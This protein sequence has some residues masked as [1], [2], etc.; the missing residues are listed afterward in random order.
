MNRCP[1]CASDVPEGKRFCGDCGAPVAKAASAPTET[2]VSGGSSDER[3]SQGSSAPSFDSQDR[4]RF[5]P[6]TVLAGRYRIVGLIGS[7]G[8]GE[9]YRADDLRLG[10]PVALKFL[11]AEFEKDP[12]RLSRFMGEVRIARQVTHPNVCR[13]YDVGEADGK[14]F[15]SMEYV[16]GEDLGSLL[17]RIGRLP[18]DK[19]VQLAR[20]VC[21]GLAAAH[22]QGILHRDLK[23]ANVMIDGRGRARLTDF[24]LAGLA[25]A[26]EGAEV[27]AGTPAY[28]APE[29]LSGKGVSMKSDLY[30]LGLVLY[31]LFTGKRAFDAPTAAELM[32]LQQESTPAMP[33]THVSGLDPAV[34]SVILRCLDKEPTQRP[35]SALAVAAA[36]PGGDPLAAA[37]AAGETPS[38][39]MV[40]AAGPEGGLR[41]VVGLIC[42]VLVLAGITGIAALAGRSTIYGRLAVQ[43][44][45]AALVE[46]A[47]EIAGKLGYDEPP[48]DSIGY[49]S[50][51][52]GSYR[53]LVG[54]GDSI[55]EHLS[56]PGQV[57]VHFYY[58]QSPRKLV[59]LG[60]GGDIRPDDPRT[61]PGGVN[62]N[63]DLQGR[64]AWLRAGPPAVEFS[65]EPPPEMDWSVLFELAGL[66]ESA[67]EPV[68]PT[69]QPRVFGDTRMAWTGTLPEAGDMPVRIEAA[70]FRGKPVYHHR[71]HGLP[72]DGR[73]SR[74]PGPA[75]LEAGK[76]RSQGRPSIGD[77]RLRHE[78]AELAD[79][80]PSRR[81]VRG[82]HPL[83]HR[84][85]RS[86]GP[87][88]D[89]VGP[90]H[91]PRTLRAATVAP[92]DRVVE[93]F[94]ERSFPRS[95]R[96]KGRAARV[97]ARPRT[98]VLQRD[99]VDGG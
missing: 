69:I 31:E 89:D 67:F 73:R 92:G 84:G 44:P 50:F 57:L 41:P 98:S 5:L 33:T 48:E 32:R 90:L 54:E 85:E 4:S 87:G 56:L 75:Q 51:N 65:E 72:R 6:G 8:M 82:R 30:S 94:A 46:N 25:E 23:P 28:M 39:E 7:G 59:T 80:W 38:P 12:S 40:A 60:F 36:L 42:L 83:H 13:V 74:L 61:R 66:D 99:H 78:D 17:R 29:Q 22:D 2:S 19:A 10:Q 88:D 11:P 45:M 1:S 43:K 86:T 34:E 24:G 9:V 52:I 16:D 14:H 63:L 64:L 21:A 62:L 79:R 15:L 70:A 27:R 26:F 55:A 53:H 81:R 37:L 18:Q 71:H 97:D 20:Q 35:T 77:L 58:R 47:R 95:P 93:P 3:V 49:F 96:R 91:G 76:G 68:P